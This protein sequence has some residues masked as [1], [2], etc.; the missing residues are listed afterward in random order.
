MLTI[1]SEMETDFHNLH[2]FQYQIHFE[3]DSSCIKAETQP[4]TNQFKNII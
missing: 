2:Q 4:K 3:L 1:S